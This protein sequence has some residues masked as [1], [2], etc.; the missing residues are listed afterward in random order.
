[1]IEDNSSGSL[2]EDL[3][4]SKK[5]VTELQAII[6]QQKNEVTELIQSVVKFKCNGFKIQHFSLPCNWT[7]WLL[8]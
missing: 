3:D 2:A 7:D 4:T 1:M 5:L 6:N 8:Q